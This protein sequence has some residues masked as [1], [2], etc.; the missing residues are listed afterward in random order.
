MIRAVCREQGFAEREIYNL[1]KQTPWDEPLQSAN[2]LSL[3]AERKLLDLRTSSAK[4]GDKAMKALA[5]YLENPNPDCLV[6]ITSPKLEPAGTRTKGFKSLD[7]HMLWVTIWP[8]EIDKLPSWI[9]GRLRQK[10]MTA[11]R[12]A[13]QMLAERV[14]GN[15]LAAQQ[16]IDK[17]ALAVEGNTIDRAS[18]MRTVADS[19]RYDVFGLAEQVLRGEARAVYRTL[20]GLRAEGID[21]TVVLWAIARELRRLI[22]LRQAIDRGQRVEAVMD[23]QRIWK[24]QQGMFRSACQRLNAPELHSALAMAH[25]VDLAIKGQSIRKP[26]DLLA[27]LCL[28]LAGRNCN[29]ASPG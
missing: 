4:P 19:A 9:D 15:L 5:S 27:D 24:N 7:R 12:E 10:G 18:I 25:E 8:V 28:L 6:L 21:A 16:E 17:L 14:E 2:S 1:D 29:V 20:R 23:Q 3:F 22:H 11:D 13:L 26:W